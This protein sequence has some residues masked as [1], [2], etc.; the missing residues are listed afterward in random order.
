MSLA[1][2]ICS[3]EFRTPELSLHL[4]Y[5]LGFLPAFLRFPLIFV[6]SIYLRILSISSFSFF[7]FISSWFYIA[8][9]MLQFIHFSPTFLIFIHV[10][11]NKL[12]ISML[13]RCV[14]QHFGQ[15]LINWC[16]Y[17]SIER[18]ETSE[19]YKS[20]FPLLS[21]RERHSE[22]S[23]NSLKLASSSKNV[24]IFGEY[25]TESKVRD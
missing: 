1:R 17:R 23:W 2:G 5:S 20:F 18:R 15:L 21:S 13:S 8:R 19:K 22:F 12:Y 6:P 24:S 9:S 25:R 3:F 11:W 14:T 10:M 4:V 7:F 16:I